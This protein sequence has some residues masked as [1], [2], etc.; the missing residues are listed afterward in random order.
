V[1]REQAADGVYRK[2]PKRLAGFTAATRALL[3]VAWPALVCVTAVF[4]GCGEHRQPAPPSK[5]TQPDQT[6]I[7][8]DGV[9]FVPGPPMA[10]D[11]HSRATWRKLRFVHG[12]LTL[13]GIGN[14]SSPTA[15]VCPVDHVSVGPPQANHLRQ[16]TVWAQLIAHCKAVAQTITLRPRGWSKDTIAAP[17]PLDIPDPRLT[18]QP[19]LAAVPSS[20]VLQADR[21]SIVVAYTLGG[22]HDLARTTATLTGKQVT[23]S[24]TDGVDP[25][26]PDDIACAESLVT[27]YTLARL[28]TPAPPHAIISVVSCGPTDGT[29]CI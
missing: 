28:S 8:K 9:H 3:A 12:R 5:K 10:S 24:V 20:A 11:A 27:G 7:T 29:D 16:V 25:N 14:V 21:R 23:V 26:L 4:A 13:A 17:G 6:F 15:P 19:L 22:C 2:I 18:D 1:D